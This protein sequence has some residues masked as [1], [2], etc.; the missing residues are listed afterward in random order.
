MSCEVVGVAVLGCTPHKSTTTR[1]GLDSRDLDVCSCQ[2]RPRRRRLS[3]CVC[4]PP[5]PL[6]TYRMLV[7]RTVIP[8]LAAAARSSFP[9]RWENKL[10]SC[11]RPSPSSA[12][13]SATF[14]YLSP[15]NQMSVSLVAHSLP[16]S[17]PPSSVRLL[18]YCSVSVTQSCVRKLVI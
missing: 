15:S 3:V 13:I 7:S 6:P 16:P 5:Q 1:S 18:F 14:C 2:K 8:N 4:S 17:L 10:R 12:H 9:T 11:R